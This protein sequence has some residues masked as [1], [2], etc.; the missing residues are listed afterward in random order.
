VPDVVLEL[1]GLPGRVD[2]TPL[3]LVVGVVEEVYRYVA[4]LY[5]GNGG[6]VSL[7][8]QVHADDA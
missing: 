2:P 3:V 6:G 1:D 5:Y 4:A 8:A 7:L